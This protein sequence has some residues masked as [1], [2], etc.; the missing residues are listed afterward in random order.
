MA[1][2][3]AVQPISAEHFLRTAER[4]LQAVRKRAVATARRARRLRRR[5]KTAKR[6]HKL[7]KKL[8]D[9]ELYE[10]ARIGELETWN[11]KYAEVMEALD[12]ALVGSEEKNLYDAL[13]KTRTTYLAS[14]NKVV[15]LVV[16]EKKH[17]EAV[18]L[19]ASDARPKLNAY[20]ASIKT[21]FTHQKKTLQTDGRRIHEL[22]GNARLVSLVGI[23]LALA[24]GV[25]AGI[26]AMAIIPR[27]LR[28]KAQATLETAS[29]DPEK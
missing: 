28:A 25:L 23:V 3:S 21:L 27:R 12:K 22:I 13:K 17:A 11:R 10:A 26:V 7:A 16:K 9:P 8:A 19:W 6:A 29:P 20:T 4:L 24:I 5:L 2:K 18:A 1:R 14:R 15:D